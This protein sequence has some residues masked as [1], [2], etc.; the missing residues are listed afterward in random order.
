MQVGWAGLLTAADC[1]V[2][3]RLGIV[4]VEDVG[5]NVGGVVGDHFVRRGSKAL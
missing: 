1:L 4:L 5:G 2:V 3:K